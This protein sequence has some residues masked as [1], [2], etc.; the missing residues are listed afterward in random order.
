MK[1]RLIELD[2][3][4]G[5]AAISVVLFHYFYRYN[6]L[7]GHTNISINW[8]QWGQ[9]GVQLFFII[10][11]FVIYW[12]LNKVRSPA[13]FIVSRFSRLYPVYWF[14]ALITLFSINLF[15][16]SGR[17]ID[18]N[19]AIWNILMFHQY[20]GIQSIDGV[21]WTLAVELTFYFW[22]FCFFLIGQ[23]KKA[24]VFFSSFL[25]LAIMD[26]SGYIDLPKALQHILML[27]H[28]SFFIAGICFYKIVNEL[29]NKWTYGILFFS[30]I[31]TIATFS[32][33]LCI[34][35]F[36][37]YLVF[38]LAI[39]KRGKFISC[40]PLLFLGGVS[41]PLYL[42]HQNIGYIIINIFYTYELNPYLGII[43]ALILSIA[44]AVIANLYVERK[45]T[46]YIRN[47]YNIFINKKNHQ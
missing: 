12:T 37:F 42:I 31:T 46:T 11:G 16:L 9:Y 18:I 10:S 40:R 20:L 3:L 29:H 27:E 34:V 25:I 33:I 45:A 14:C 41:Y 15:G 39:T 47:T 5:I 35:F 22:I 36:C 17:E 19:H 8:A 2:G 6:E 32:L 24:E 28:I 38:Y 43:T 30:L 4:R 26:S 13:D 44:L 7:Y 21:Y 23:L 1:K